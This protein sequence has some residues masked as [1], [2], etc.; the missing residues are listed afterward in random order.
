MG[1]A[2]PEVEAA[3]FGPIKA[4]LDLESGIAQHLADYQSRRLNLLPKV[5]SNCIQYPP[6]QLHPHATGCCKTK[7]KAVTVLFSL[8]P[9]AAPSWLG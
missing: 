2:D 5:D 3:T 7:D 6:L 1:R 8:C 4:Y 9:A